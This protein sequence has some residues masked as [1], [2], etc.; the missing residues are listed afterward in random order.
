MTT[1]DIQELRAKQALAI[2]ALGL[3][4]YRWKNASAPAEGLSWWGLS[5]IASVRDDMR[6]GVGLLLHYGRMV[7]L[8]VSW[9]DDDRDDEWLDR[10]PYVIASFDL[11]QLAKATA[12]EYRRK[13]ATLTALAA[14]SP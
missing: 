1:D 6:P 10:P 3:I 7:T 5:A 8:G 13:L 14:T 2:E 11:F 12:P 9:H 4:W